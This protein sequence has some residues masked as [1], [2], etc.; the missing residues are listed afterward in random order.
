MPTDHRILL[1]DRGSIRD[2]SVGHAGLTTDQESV[3][4]LIKFLKK[5]LSQEM[6]KFQQDMLRSIDLQKNLDKSVA[7][8][9]HQVAAWV[10]DMF[11]IF[12]LVK[13]HDIASNSTTTKA[14]QK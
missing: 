10:S 2:H 14:R 7:S 13:S 11:C 9:C 12:Y 1:S 6:K 4:E 3:M 5:N 8:F